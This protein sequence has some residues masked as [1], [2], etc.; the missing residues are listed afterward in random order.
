MATL[1]PIS[2]DLRLS[3]ADPDTMYLDEQMRLLRNDLESVGIATSPKMA[4]PPEG[5][6]GAMEILG[7]VQLALLPTLGPKLIDVLQ[8]WLANRKDGSIKLK[9]TRDEIDIEFNSDHQDWRQIDV[10]ITRTV[11]HLKT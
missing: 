11:S 5:A 4:T 9:I 2:I 3:F 1:T 7:L 8:A 10:L 6:R